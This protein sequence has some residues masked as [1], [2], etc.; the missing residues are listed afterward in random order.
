PSSLSSPHLHSVFSPIINVSSSALPF[1]NTPNRPSTPVH[2]HIL[3]SQPSTRWPLP[4]RTPS[5]RRKS[6][7]PQLSISYLRL[8]CLR[9][10]RTP[11]ES[12]TEPTPSIKHLFAHLPS[13]FEMNHSSSLSIFWRPQLSTTLRYSVLLVESVFQEGV[14]TLAKSPTFAFARDPRQL[15]FEVDLN[16]LFFYTS[17]NRLGKNAS[18]TEAEEII[19]IASKASIADQQ[20]LVQEMFILK[21][22]HFAHKWM[23][24]F[25]QIK[26]RGMTARLSYYLNKQMFYLEIVSLVPPMVS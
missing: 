14:K 17:Y 26:R 3:L 1:K 18:E 19:E 15:Q 2:Q 22:K 7:P 12:I 25:L 23:K 9:P 8:P 5:H 6:S 16:R 10:N 13:L 20:M 24:F 4:N 11:A 21:L